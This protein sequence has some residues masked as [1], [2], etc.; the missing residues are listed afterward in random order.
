VLI[1]PQTGHIVDV[2]KDDP[3]DTVLAD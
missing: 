2:R 3:F 1:S